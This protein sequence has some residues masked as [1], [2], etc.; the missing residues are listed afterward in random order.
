MSDE[1]DNL[2]PRLERLLRRWGAEQAAAGAR[3]G[4]LAGQEHPSGGRPVSAG[5]WRW[6][7]AAAA[8]VLLAG[9]AYLYVNRPA[10]GGAGGSGGADAARQGPQT[11]PAEAAALA[12]LRK[13]LAEKE[14]AL[15]LAEGEQRRLG[16][17]VKGASE[18][19]GL[20][21]RQVG[22]AGERG[23]EARRAVEKLRGQLQM[24][25]AEK[26]RLIEESGAATA[27]RREDAAKLKRM[28][29]LE[30]ETARLRQLHDQAVASEQ[31][32]REELRAGRA[33]QAAALATARRAYLQALAGEG[34]G[35]V[36]A[37]Q[38]AARK[39]RM[40]ERCAE[41]AG[42][43]RSGKAHEAM[44]LVEEALTRLELVD[45]ANLSECR[46]FV[47]MIREKRLAERI[48]EALTY[49]ELETVRV[50]L[51]E[52]SLIL[53]GADDVG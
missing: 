33:A 19:I 24:V 2:D 18:Q 26:S 10:G 20:L 38:I 3:P 11:S 27:A 40:L 15:R 4:A 25:Q 44:A 46:R 47:E 50:W 35:G 28:Q 53:A 37:M 21:G 32:A 36:E 52:A 34:V 23:E 8:A 12:R 13:E 7:P 30:E 43:M 41:V 51:V 9:A 5:L 49:V 48:D 39:R 16:Q 29:L 6:A 14:Q 1:G 42:R 17:Q 31:R 22:Q 45:T